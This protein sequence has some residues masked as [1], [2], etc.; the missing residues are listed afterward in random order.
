MIGSCDNCSRR[1]VP[2]RHIDSPHAGDTT[3]CYVC[4]G[5]IDPD[6]YGE[7]ERQRCQCCDPGELCRG[8]CRSKVTYATADEAR[9]DWLTIAPEHRTEDRLLFMLSQVKRP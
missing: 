1:N 5:D 2:V 8:F 7:L 6:P 9:A 3:Q 4:T